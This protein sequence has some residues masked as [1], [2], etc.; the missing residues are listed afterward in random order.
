MSPELFAERVEVYEALV[1]WDRRLAR[2]A[3]FFRQLF[4]E[5]SVRR[6]VDTACGTGH[7]AAM[8]HSWGLEVEA[9]DISSE[10]IAFAEKQFGRPPGLRWVVRSFEQPIDSPEPFHAAVCLGNSL[11]L[12]SDVQAVR[13]ALVAMLAAVQPGGLVIV[14]VL[15]LLALDDG[16]CRW[17]KCVP[18]A[19]D[20][21][22]RLILKGVHRS[23]DSGYVD[24]AIVDLDTL[25]LVHTESTRFL[26]LTGPV[27]REGLLAAGADRVDLLGGY[28]GRPYEESS[29]PD[30]LAI[31]RRGAG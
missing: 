29:S 11:A 31:A 8:F 21:S 19:T 30:L 7:H 14:Q 26:G 22:R 23:G 9:A 4:E 15:N 3:P 5:A 16:P 17:Q 2:E 13:R 25:Q 27:L 1:D 12:A 28:D 6:V 20:R 24:L 18:L 10:M